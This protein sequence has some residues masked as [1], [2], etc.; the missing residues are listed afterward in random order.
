MFYAYVANRC[1]AVLTALVLSKYNLTTFHSPLC[2]SV[3]FVSIFQFLTVISCAHNFNFHV[4][5]MPMMQATFGHPGPGS[6]P[7]HCLTH[8]EEG[9]HRL[10]D[11]AFG[12]RIANGFGGKV[13]NKGKIYDCDRHSR[14]RS[15]LP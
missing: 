10:A 14:V 15:F 8:C 3:F 11:D 5:M 7:T 9:M 2:V 4:L 13:W 6:V 12:S 1:C